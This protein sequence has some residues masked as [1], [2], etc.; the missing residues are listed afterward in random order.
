MIKAAINI[1]IILVAIID[2]GF[3][4]GVRTLAAVGAGSVYVCLLL[5]VC[6]LGIEVNAPKRFAL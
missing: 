1:T 6:I 2:L 4:D 5:L 3:F